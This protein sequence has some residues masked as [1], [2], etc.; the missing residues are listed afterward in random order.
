MRPDANYAQRVRE[1][2]LGGQHVAKKPAA[3][4][5][6]PGQP[7]TSPR[8]LR[9]AKKKARAAAATTDGTVIP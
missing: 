6:H 5:P 4:S 9:K 8:K 2:M 1:F 3:V 7:V